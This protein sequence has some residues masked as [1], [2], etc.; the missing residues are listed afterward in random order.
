MSRKT[1]EISALLAWVY[2]EEMPKLD[3]FLEDERE[4]WVSSSSPWDAIER[5]SVLGVRVDT[6]GRAPDGRPLDYPDPDAYVVNEAV[7]AIAGWAIG[8]PEGWDALGDCTG[9]TDG[10][11]TDAYQRGWAIAAMRGDRLGALVMRRAL[12]GGEPTWRDHGPI[13]RRIVRKAN[14]RPAW[15]R[16]VSDAAGD[17]RPSLP[18]EVDG[19]NP[20]GHRAYTGAYHKHYLDPCPSLLIAERIE[21][22]AWALALQHLAATVAYRLTRFDVLPCDVPLWPWED[23][24]RSRSPRVLTV[25]PPNDRP[26][27]ASNVA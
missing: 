5:L 6:S 22:Q 18:R 27:D 17:G 19:W 4:Q 15:F 3:R 26:C 21:Y 7:R 11:R 9:L 10:E 14:G 16:M 20:K 23:V 12:V 2:R 13:Y 24:E 8:M 1:I 25:R